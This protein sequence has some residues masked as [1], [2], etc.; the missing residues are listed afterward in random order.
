MIKERNQSRVVDR[1]R[2][3]PTARPG[4]RRTPAQVAARDGRTEQRILDAAHAVFLRSGTAGA[5]T[6][7][8]AREAG[9]NAALLHYYFRSKEQLAAAVFRRVARE[10]FP[11]IIGVLASDA[12]LETK[13]REVVRLELDHLSRTPGLP[14]YLLCELNHHADRPAQFLEAM[15]GQ[16]PAE[17]GVRV[18]EVLGAQ[19]AREVRAG[20]IRRISF[21]Q[22]VVNLL[23][24]CVFPFAARPMFAAFLGFDDAGFHAFI[25][26][27]RKDLPTFMLQGL[28]P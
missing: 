18:R 25:D 13:V 10:V 21:E 15:M 20:R 2:R 17:V 5:R 22:F 12:D 4:A 1:A 9:V 19:I 28:R 8:I 24:L 16:A 27:R 23:A 11:T 14:A 3:S 7:E 26:A 6:Q